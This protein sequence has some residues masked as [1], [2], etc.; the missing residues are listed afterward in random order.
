VC[1][2][3]AEI[4]RALAFGGTPPGVEAAPAPAQA[5][6]AVAPST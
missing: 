2:P 5:K 3:P 4:A 1:E 6:S